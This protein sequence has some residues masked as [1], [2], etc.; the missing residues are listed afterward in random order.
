M[1]W[2]GER[3]S[4]VHSFI[5]LASLWHHRPTEICF[6]REAKMDKA[7]IAAC[8]FLE[9]HMN[10]VSDPNDDMVIHTHLHN[11]ACQSC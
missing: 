10:E 5:H 11:A 8:H 7:F 1:E 2:A 4:H 6:P 3:K 9:D